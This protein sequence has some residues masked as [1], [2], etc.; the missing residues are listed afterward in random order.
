[1]EAFLNLL[2][3]QLGLIVVG[4][5]LLIKG[6]NCLVDGACA[7]AKRFHVP[8]LVIGLTIVA[9]GTS[10]PEL[11]VSVTSAIKGNSEIAIGNVLGSNI[12]N[13][14]LV[15]GGAGVI[16]TI[17]FARE[18]V[19]REVYTCIITAL[20]LLAVV[21]INPSGV[22]VSRLEA[23]ILLACMVAYMIFLVRT[24]RTDPPPDHVHTSH[25]VSVS[26]MML[27]GGL[28]ALLFGGDL[29][30]KNA[31][32]VAT[33]MKV[34]QAMIGLTV[35][36]LGTSLP[37]LATSIVSLKKGKSDIAIGNIVG[38][39]IMNTCLVLGCAAA[40]TPIKTAKSF[41]MDASVATVA[42]ILL[43]VFMFTGKKSREL[44]RKE[45][46]IYILCYITYIGF[47]IWR[48]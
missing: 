15:L 9:F 30:V 26:I 5:V 31:V 32:K 25:K 7:I 43:L 40:I 44:D 10:A 23:V 38:S 12:A 41:I 37:E 8:D 6:A 2:P 17:H 33:T 1:M 4:F 45:A 35:I 21:S 16:F 46:A 42:S 22:L 28:I 34:S 14:C 27:I 19:R 24:T 39:N 20:L 13:L 11:A 3:V 36:A 47:V 29:I 48:K 18:R